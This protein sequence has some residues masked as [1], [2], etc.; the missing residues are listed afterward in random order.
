MKIGIWSDSVNF[1]NL[2]LM[3]L[4]AYH[5]SLGD[6]V[7][8]IQEGGHYDKVYL[9]KVFNLPLVKKIPQT[10]PLFY[11]D[12]ID[13]GGTGYAIQIEDGKEVFHKELHKDLPLEIENLYPD[14]ELYP[15]FSEAYGFLTRGCCNNCSFCIVC[16]KEGNCSRR[17]SELQDFWRGQKQIKLLDPNILACRDREELLKQLIE[18]RAQIDFTQGLDARF[19][20]DEIVK[21]LLQM[22][23]KA[24]HFAFDF[25]K[26]EQA[27]IRGFQCFNRTYTRS[28]WN[29]K[30]YILTNYDT[31]HEEDWYRVCKVREN[32]LIPDI[33]IY[34]KGTQDQ[35]L[36]DLQGWCNNFR[37]FRSTEFADYVP[38][39]DG[40][41]C[42]ELY[43]EILRKKKFLWLRKNPQPNKPLST[44]QE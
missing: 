27:I 19:I 10:P 6:E 28:K 29:V 5:K 13:K 39:V 36:T 15:Q 34:Q 18:S 8:F 20:N 41:T 16:P 4:S 38:R 1:P 23:V 43:P 37:L 25:M 22:R 33:R 21:M 32:G 17:V 14:Y 44:P 7:S 40:K 35:F 26:N 2:P 42:G 24:I 30:C 11:A 3:K 12:E 9:S 31:T